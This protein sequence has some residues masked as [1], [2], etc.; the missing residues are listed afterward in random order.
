MHNIKRRDKLKDLK[1]I[2]S[3]TKKTT[4]P[5]TK[6]EA[7]EREYV[8]WNTQPVP[9]LDEFVG[10]NEVINPNIYDEPFDCDLPKGY[11]YLNLDINNEDHLMKMTDFL[12]KYYILNEHSKFKS[13]YSA[14]FLKWHF[15]KSSICLAVIVEKTQML[16]GLITAQFNKNQ[17]YTTQMNVAEVNFM[18]VHPIIR[19]K[20]L[21]PILIKSLIGK[22]KSISPEVKQSL[23]MTNTYL[24]KPFSSVHY[25]NRPI[26]IEPLLE[27]GLNSLPE[28]VTVETIKKNLHL[29]KTPI[30]RFVKLDLNYVADAMNVLNKY[31]GKFT[32]HPVFTEDEFKHVF[33]NN[34]FVSSYVF[35]N[36]T[37]NEVTDFASYYKLPTKSVDDKYN[38]ECGYLYYYSSN[39]ETIMT[40]L[41]NILIIAKNDGMQTFNAL[42]IMENNINLTDLKF[43]E[44]NKEI[45]YY[46][47]NYKCVGMNNNQLAKIMF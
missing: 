42:N 14:S 7:S 12:D 27:S 2:K 18:C 8:F 15:K 1:N 36:E 45:Y 23:F 13:Y 26:Q 9:G 35:L 47:Y 10:R 28:N 41:N 30:S 34:E 22:I 40:I 11:I 37:S 16:V 32:C 29:S 46:M 31:F 43:E 39:V 38:I 17:I 3:G 25:Y 44:S 20:R 33:L 19:K 21:C 4:Y 6:K 5:K 24:P